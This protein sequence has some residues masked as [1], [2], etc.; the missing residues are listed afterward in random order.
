MPP[1]VFDHNFV[2]ETVQRLSKISPGAEPLWGR[3]T[4]AQ[5]IGHLAVGLRYTMG[6]LPAAR[7]WGGWH[8]RWIVAPLI[9][10]GWLRIPRNT[11]APLPR[12]MRESPPEEDVE[13]LHALMEEY[14]QKS[15]AGEIALPPHPVFGPLSADDWARFHA[16]HFD[17]HLR[18]FGV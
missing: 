3:M 1:P 11:P 10:R 2:E 16:V 15:E 17:H 9:L 5:M 7:R 13:T 4:P 6:R 8:L 18:Q 14:L 12:S